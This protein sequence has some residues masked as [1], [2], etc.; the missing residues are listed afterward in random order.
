MGRWGGGPGPPATPWP[1]A[2]RGVG[3]PPRDRLGAGPVSNLVGPAF[4]SQEG[5]RT[6]GAYSR[7]SL[8][9][10][11][12]LPE[13]E[14]PVLS[15]R[16]PARPGD[17]PGTADGGAPGPRP[18]GRSQVGRSAAPARA[19]CPGCGLLVGRDQERLRGLGA[20]W[21]RGCWLAGSAGRREA[22]E[23]QRAWVERHRTL[24]GYLLAQEHWGGLP[25]LVLMGVM[26]GGNVLATSFQDATDNR[27]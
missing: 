10:R 14:G 23:S 16:Q 17:P 1:E 18:P 20:W 21:H 11:S 9:D 22:L 6:D 2:R 24:A 12:R 26:D 3:A 25:G 8:A 13:P 5:L 19:P 15:A 27:G 4:V 7:G